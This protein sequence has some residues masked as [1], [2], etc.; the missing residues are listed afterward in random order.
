[1][2]DCEEYRTLSDY[3]SDYSSDQPSEASTP[4]S[5][6]IRTPNEMLTKKQI[7]KQVLEDMAE[8]FNEVFALEFW[9]V[10]K[11]KTR[12]EQLRKALIYGSKPEIS[13]EGRS[14]DPRHL[15]CIEPN[16]QNDFNFIEEF[17]KTITSS[18]FGTKFK[19]LCDVDDILPPTRG[20]YIQFEDASSS[21]L[22][23]QFC[24]KHEFKFKTSFLSTRRKKR[25]IFGVPLPNSFVPSAN[26]IKE[27]INNDFKDGN[28]FQVFYFNLKPPKSI[29]LPNGDIPVNKIAFIRGD[30]DGDVLEKIFPSCVIHQIEFP[31]SFFI[32]FPSEEATIAALKQKYDEFTLL[33]YQYRKMTCTARKLTEIVQYLL[34]LPNISYIHQLQETYLLLWIDAGYVDGQQVTVVRA[35]IQS[36]LFEGKRSKSLQWIKIEGPESSLYQ[37]QDFINE[38][39]DDVLD[40][41]VEHGNIKFIIQSCKIVTDE[42]AC[43]E[44]MNLAGKFACS[45]CDAHPE[46]WRFE[47]DAKQTLSLPL[48]CSLFDI[49]KSD[50]S[51]IFATKKQKRNQ[52]IAFK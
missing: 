28:L 25:R 38:S 43:W 45:I 22:F 31:P 39:L 3:G 51:S 41:E 52:K 10:S 46:Q 2:E 27:S 5:S 32:E 21:R 15:V 20:F 8:N 17:E 40:L 42:K 36:A 12:Y 19:T 29:A 7:V 23:Y 14:L 9:A 26:K 18:E 1:M 49:A 4:S 33:P 37:I 34:S 44:L 35:A 50:I 47:P 30:C 13:Y 11:S 24:S 48:R 16:E 6:P